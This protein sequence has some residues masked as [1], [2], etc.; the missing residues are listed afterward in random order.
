MRMQMGTGALVAILAQMFATERGD[1]GT[2]GERTYRS[3]ESS[4][5]TTTI[6]QHDRLATASELAAE[7]S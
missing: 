4:K 1:C 7:T 2:D 6:L 5:W 3:F